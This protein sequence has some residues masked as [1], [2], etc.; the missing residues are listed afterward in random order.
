VTGTRG[1]QFAIMMLKITS[2]LIVFLI[3]FGFACLGTNWV[4][5][6]IKVTVFL[7]VLFVA[8][9]IGTSIETLEKRSL[10]IS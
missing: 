4:P 1:W 2:K 7:M 6:F 3:S 8:T 9:I 5:L 10:F